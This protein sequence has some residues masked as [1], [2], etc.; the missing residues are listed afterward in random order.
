MIELLSAHQPLPVVPPLI[1]QVEP[2]GVGPVFMAVEAS[3]QTLANRRS[4]LAPGVI[5]PPPCV[6]P[7]EVWQEPIETFSVDGCPLHSVRPRPR[8]ATCPPV[9]PV[10]VKVRV[11]ARVVEAT[12]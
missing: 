7:L 4:E 6:P 12:V 8:A 11:S 5:V 9:P 1:G 10:A 3:E 2:R